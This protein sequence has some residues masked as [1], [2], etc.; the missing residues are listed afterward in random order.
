M[1]WLVKCYRFDGSQY[2]VSA[3]HVL[4]AVIPLWPFVPSLLRVNYADD[5]RDDGNRALCKWNPNAGRQHQCC[6]IGILDR[7]FH[8]VL[9]GGERRKRKNYWFEWFVGE[10]PFSNSGG[11]KI[12]SFIFSTTSGAKWK[13]SR[14]V[15]TKTRLAESNNFQWHFYTWI[16]TL[17]VPF[18]T[19][20]F[21][22]TKNEFIAQKRIYC[23]IECQKYG[24][25]LGKSDWT[26]NYSQLAFKINTMWMKSFFPRKGE[27]L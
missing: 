9:M 17:S 15:Q 1:V 5:E 8:C 11:G 3:R 22:C 27:I 25:L 6:L 26:P 4:V 16:M 20:D 18:S 13:K 14:S 21:C 2:W 7:P 12:N 23:R 24:K 19:V 10:I